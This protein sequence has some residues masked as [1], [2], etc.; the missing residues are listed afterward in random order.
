MKLP[1]RTSLG[2]SYATVTL[3]R[4]KVKTGY[5]VFDVPEALTL[6]ECSIQVK[7]PDASP[8]WALGKTP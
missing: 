1:T 4:Y 5:I 2:E 7:L 6:D 3:D 8:V